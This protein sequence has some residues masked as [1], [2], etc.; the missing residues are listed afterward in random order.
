ME[1]WDVYD[2]DRQLTGK[3]MVRGESF[4]EGAYHI[5]VH[6]CVF[7]SE[8]KMLIQQRQPFK[9]GWP[10]MWDVTCGGSAVKG[11]T[12]RDAAHRELLEEIGIDI[13]FSDSRPDMTV[14]FEH[15][16]DDIYIAKKDIDISTLKLQYEE[17]KTVKW[18]D[19]EEILS[20]IDNGEFIPYYKNFIS[21]LF[22]KRKGGKGCIENKMETVVKQFEE[23]TVEELYE[24]LRLRSE[25][26]VVEQDCVYQDIDD[27]DKGA[28]HVFLRD[29]DGLEAYLRVLD[30][31][32]AFEEVSV[33]RVVTKKREQ[34]FGKKIMEAG[35]KVAAEKLGADKIRIVAQ[36]Y[37]EG[38]YKKMG[39]VTVSEEF[40]YDGI[41]HVYMVW[42]KK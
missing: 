24:I 32:A 18:S 8:G 7:N 21:L 2:A 3:T 30:K 1:L 33:G 11:E 20:M 9:H 22:D 26:F 5:V 27:K 16:F 37:A 34:G 10:D 36:S 29:D 39:F 14:N 31:G 42:E 38:F 25:V 6:V 28:W 23:L 12:S 17:V 19:C 35:I 40:M 13:D 41:P 4:E 15:G